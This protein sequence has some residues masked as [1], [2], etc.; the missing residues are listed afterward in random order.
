[1]TAKQSLCQKILSNLKD[2]SLPV[3]VRCADRF[4]QERIASRLAE[5]LTEPSQPPPISRQM[6]FSAMTADKYD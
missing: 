6:T 4:T 2:P 3:Q 1:M 5:L